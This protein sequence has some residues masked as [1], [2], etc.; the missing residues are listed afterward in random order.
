MSD[1]NGAKP[2]GATV[3]VRR[4]RNGSPQIES[5]W[6]LIRVEPESGN[7]VCQLGRQR[8]VSLRREFELLNFPGSDDLWGILSDEKGD[9]LI[10]VKTSWAK[11][12]LPGAV[13][14]LLKYARTLDPEL[15]GVQTVADI[16]QKLNEIES[17]CKRSM[18]LLRLEI[19]R[20]QSEYDRFVAQ[21]ALEY[22]KKDSLL[23]RVREAENKYAARAYRYE[24]QLPAWRR[25]VA[26]VQS[27]GAITD[28]K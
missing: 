24:T 1:A 22:D 16:V 8:I 4:E 27:M 11:L 20:A 7:T 23:A 14:G 19:K 21:T 9:E 13:G 5:G 26:V 17:V 25:L 3:R 6:S 2:I 10:K 28:K 12:D 15:S 18:D